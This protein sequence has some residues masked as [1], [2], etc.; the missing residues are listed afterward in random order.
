MAVVR[1]NIVPM[2]PVVPWQARQ[3]RAVIEE[4][5]SCAQR[6]IIFG[7]PEREYEYVM[8]SGRSLARPISS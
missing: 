1:C 4:V 8:G 2:T 6:A 3:L 5:A 7:R